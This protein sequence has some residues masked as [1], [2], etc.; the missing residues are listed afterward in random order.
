MASNVKKPVSDKAAINKAVA[1]VKATGNYTTNTMNSAVSKMTTNT[2]KNANTTA[3]AAYK[4]AAANNKQVSTE[5]RINNANLT[6]QIGNKM[7]REDYS[8]TNRNVIGAAA[9]RSG[10]VNLAALANANRNAKVTR[11][12]SKAKARAS[13]YKVK[14]AL[15]AEN[16]T[17]K[18]KRVVQA[19]EAAK[20]RKLDTAI[21][22][23]KERY[24]RTQRRLS[25][26]ANTIE[27]R[28][29]SE[30]SVKN[31]IARMKK[32]K[33]VESKSEKLAYLRALLFKIQNPETS[34]GSGGGGRGGRG[35]YGRRGYYGRGGSGSNTGGTVGD[36]GNGGNGGKGGKKYDRVALARH[37]DI[38]ANPIGKGLQMVGGRY[39]LVLPQK[40]MRKVER[41]EA[42]K[43]SKKF[44]TSKGWYTGPKWTVKKGK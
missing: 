5:N 3:N 18:A 1:P 35:G 23:R 28:Y 37:A 30:K 21:S 11:D 33:N 14:G 4:A 13:A 27:E 22:R 40:D 43:A 10:A 24:D 17:N 39:Q 36:G 8:L 9:A 6:R 38:L 19:R 7:K 41:Q 34:G 25:V 15:R 31:A 2:I 44:K 32:A 29:T 26:Y 16:I 12:V 20:G 42:K